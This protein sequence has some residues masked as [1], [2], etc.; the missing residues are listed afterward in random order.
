MSE[1]IFVKGK[2]V[3]LALLMLCMAQMA[4]A[5][6]VKRP[7]SYNYT[8]GCEALQN[9]D[10]ET[11]RAYFNN[12]INDN[13]KNGYAYLFKALVENVYDEQYGPALASANKA[14]EFIP[15]KD[16]DYRALA[17]RLR[18]K[19]HLN[20]GQY[21]LAIQ[22]YSQAIKESPHDK[23]SYEE[24]GQAYF[25]MDEYSLADKDYQKLV[26]L[27][28]DDVMGYM[29]LGRNAKEQGLYDDAIK[30]FD[31]VV[32]M[33]PNYSSGYSFRAES[34]FRLGRY[35]EAIDDIIKALEID[36]DDKAFYLMQEVADSAFLKVVPKLKIQINKEPNNYY[37]QYCL[38]GIHE[39]HE[40][41]RKA[42]EYY[43]QSYQKD[44]SPIT[45]KRIS[46]CYDEVG[47]YDTAL[48]YI[49]MALERDSTNY[50]SVQ[51]KA[52]ILDHAGRSK[53]AIREMDKC[54][55]MVP[56]YYFVYYRR[57]WI[58]DHSGDIE[59]AIEDYSMSIALRPSYAYNY[60]NR[61]VLYR[62]KG[63]NALAEDDFRKVV[64]LDTIPGDENT[65]QYA[66]FYLGER[67]KAVAFQDSILEKGDDKGNYYD[68]AC[69]YSLMGETRKSLEYL[70]K[71]LEL[72]YRNFH[73][74]RRDRDLN[75]IRD[76]EEFKAL[77]E[78]YETRHQSE[79]DTLDEDQSTFEEAT[80]EIPFTKEPGGV[81]K[82]KCSI[83]DL[84]LHFIF[85]TGASDVSMS[86]VEAS[87]MLKNGYLTSKDVEGK[88]YYQTANG[89]ISEGTVVNIRDVEFGGLHLS[90]VR[91][92]VIKNQAA[93]LLLGQSVLQKLGKFEIDNSNKVLKITYR[94]PST[95]EK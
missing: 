21:D 95:P 44:A 34:Y 91:A 53:E 47:D 71:S 43:K 81:L 92:S 65:A 42:I 82:V 36:G 14:V 35:D 48:K 56:E 54:I 31:Y 8:R 79:L 93:P 80:A 37:W 89:D 4:F 25:D 12:E 69:L 83:N 32:S 30:L 88:Q 3:L 64:E 73:H 13:P 2:G 75:N 10:F 40:D 9:E 55:Q 38:G 26:S 29:G 28:P 68:A 70:R 51:M 59:G 18:A 85:D 46:N 87:F 17:L 61:G 72:G 7:D 90:N 23:D 41:Y 66:Y 49:D 16:K 52:N 94:K 63:E 60:M 5:Q 58:K 15:K 78:E 22:D 39:A 33:H 6:K 11:A 67:E 20:M 45:A 84:P 50:G 62:L 74:I 76:T 19:I 24:R 27:D 1:M 86:A 57:G 77:M